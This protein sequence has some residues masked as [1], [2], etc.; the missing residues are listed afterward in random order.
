MRRALRLSRRG[1][2][3][4]VS[5]I[6]WLDQS[7]EEQRRV[8]ELVALFAQQESRDELGIGQI[9]D[10]FSDALFPGVSVIQ[11]RARYFLFVPWLF[12]AGQGRAGGAVLLR[13]VHN[14][15]RELIEALRSEG[16]M[17]GLIGRLAGAKVK[18]LPSTIYWHGLVRWQVLTSD[19]APDQLEPLSD[20]ASEADELVTTSR[21]EWQ[22]TLPP[23][24]KGFPEAVIGG[25]ALTQDEATWLTERVV[26]ACPGSL[27]A[28][29]TLA[30]E[31]PSP[32][33]SAPWDDPLTSS[34]AP[35]LRTWLDDARRF[36]S[37]MR[38]AALVYNL[39]LAEAY[40]RTGLDRIEAPIETY[41]SELDEWAEEI[42]SRL[43]ELRAWDRA[44]MRARVADRSPQITPRTW[45]FVDEWADIALA[46][47]GRVAEHGA[48]R[49][50]VANRERTQKGRQSRLVNERLLAT[51]SGASGARPLVY[52]WGTARTIVT[53]IVVGRRG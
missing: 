33:A 26:D 37:V 50:L 38:G 41:R 42:G 40:E 17:D 30:G 14:R 3:S 2:A 53:D 52:R 32:G 43:G 6:T 46:A 18:L 21:S 51:W 28:H 47:G 29:L 45:A 35:E 24:P 9:R 13:R 44:V 19:V 5:S 11:T 31:I 34:V 15:E 48:A 10:T 1:P 7:T 27:L 39:L 12:Q 49:S 25:F 22:A 8:R 20:A 4:S 16:A 23:P 36:S